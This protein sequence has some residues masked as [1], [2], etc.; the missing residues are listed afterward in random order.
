[1]LIQYECLDPPDWDDYEAGQE[2]VEFGVHRKNLYTRQREAYEQ[3]E[4][5]DKKK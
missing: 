1:M 2:I 4:R 5:E 3:A